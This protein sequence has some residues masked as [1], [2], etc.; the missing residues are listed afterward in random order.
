MRIVHKKNNCK[1]EKSSIQLKMHALLFFAIFWETQG[2]ALGAPLDVFFGDPAREV[3][4]QSTCF[5]YLRAD[6]TEE[7]TRRRARV[8]MHTPENAL[9]G[10]MHQVRFGEESVESR[11]VG[12]HDDPD[13]SAVLLYPG[14]WTRVQSRGM[15]FKIKNM[16]D[17]N[18]YIRQSFLGGC[19][20]NYYFFTSGGNSDPEYPR[21]T[22]DEM[23]AASVGMAYRHF[24]GR[25]C[26][27]A[28]PLRSR[29]G[30][31]HLDTFRDAPVKY[32]ED[33]CRVM[34]PAVVQF[35]RAWKQMVGRRCAVETES[36]FEFLPN[37]RVRHYDPV[38]GYSRVLSEVR[39]EH[40]AGN[41]VVFYFVGSIPFYFDATTLRPIR[42]SLLESGC[43]ERLA[44]S[45]I[46]KR[47]S[48]AASG[49][50][51]S[52]KNS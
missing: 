33:S 2:S 34:Y 9:E 50:R 30:V 16:K 39:M 17:A 35:D 7:T 27:D 13:M 40:G 29:S 42:S 18:V 1:T 43:H 19:V 12:F 36:F 31:Q 5:M 25:H 21:A 10:V 46:R 47:T 38:R 41:T 22:L 51:R 28:S 8:M 3:P 48:L 23:P 26:I 15:P 37:Y 45:M 24:Q 49:W 6:Y 4:V 32:T 14:P 52:A 11:W 44:D 20:E